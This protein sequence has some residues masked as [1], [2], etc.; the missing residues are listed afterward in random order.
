MNNI[1]KSIFIDANSENNNKTK[2][3]KTTK[4]I[5][6]KDSQGEAVVVINERG[7]LEFPYRKEDEKYSLINKK[8]YQQCVGELIA[9]Q[10]EKIKKDFDF[11][12]IGLL[13]G[14]EMAFDCNLPHIRYELYKADKILETYN[15]CEEYIDVLESEI[16]Y[17]KGFQEALINAIEI[18]RD[19][20]YCRHD[21]NIA[22]IFNQI[23][24]EIADNHYFVKSFSEYGVC[25][26]HI[27]REMPKEPVPLNENQIVLY[28]APKNTAVPT[29]EIEDIFNLSS[30]I[31]VFVIQKKGRFKTTRIFDNIEQI[32]RKN[33]LLGTGDECFKIDPSMI[34]F[35]KKYDVLLDDSNTD[36]KLENKDILVIEGE[37]EIDMRFDTEYQLKEYEFKKD[38]IIESI[39][40]PNNLKS[41]PE[42]LLYG[43]RKLDYVTLPCELKSIGI[44]AF[45]GCKSLN[46][47]FMPDTIKEISSRAFYG[48]QELKKIHLP[49]SL[50]YIGSEAFAGCSKLMTLHFPPS[51][52]FVANDSFDGCDSLVKIEAPTG[53]ILPEKLLNKVSVKYYSKR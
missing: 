49:D 53:I 41:I 47:I 16:L 7:K 15:E 9:T 37:K 24:P 3:K 44:S 42:G 6:F 14:Y 17:Y 20:V 28:I 31:P 33:C 8:E 52:R 46:K 11:Y 50:E 19:N 48:C 27:Y 34:Q 40:L 29:K 10:N 12:Q 21:W 45:E 13:R 32:L 22:V 35:L 5:I 2:T 43:C 30:T 23:T 26:I 51:I 25:K 1:S 39:K 4:N 36:K 38:G 18:Q